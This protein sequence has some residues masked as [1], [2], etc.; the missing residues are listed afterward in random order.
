MPDPTSAG[1]VH[2]SVAL[3]A[4]AAGST[5]QARSPYA[6]FSSLL[7]SIHAQRFAELVTPLNATVVL[8][9]SPGTNVIVGELIQAATPSSLFAL[10]ASEVQRGTASAFVLAYKAEAWSASTVAP[11]LREPTP[12]LAT[13]EDSYVVGT[14]PKSSAMLAVTFQ[15]SSL[16]VPP[17]VCWNSSNSTVETVPLSCKEPHTA[18]DPVVLELH[19]VLLA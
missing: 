14:K 19:L 9:C 2:V 18:E 3:V 12:W 15:V 16:P 13:P 7:K 17:E 4:F 6:K 1:T 11:N 5:A 8:Y 10:F